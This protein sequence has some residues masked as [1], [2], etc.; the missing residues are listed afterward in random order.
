MLKILI[1]PIKKNQGLNP[2]I[3]DVKKVVGI[4]VYRIPIDCDFQSGPD[5]T[6]DDD[7]KI[8]LP[9]L[10]FKIGPILIILRFF[11]NPNIPL[12]IMYANYYRSR[13]ISTNSSKPLDDILARPKQ[14]N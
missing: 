1:I 3:T 13:C 6:L 2:T 5:I 12:A 9:E 4:C 8:E 10:L 14:R 11:K 7:Q